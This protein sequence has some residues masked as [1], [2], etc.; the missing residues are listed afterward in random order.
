MFDNV[1]AR[2]ETPEGGHGRPDR[3]LPPSVETLLARIRD[4]LERVVPE[5]LFVPDTWLAKQLH[6]PK[7]TLCNRRAADKKRYPTPMHPGGCRQGLHP[8]S[9]L[10]EWLA[11]EELRYILGPGSCG[12]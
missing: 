9:V 11:R 8:R 7:K 10:I 5:G 4:R 6:M 3:P 1:D 12:T 2:D